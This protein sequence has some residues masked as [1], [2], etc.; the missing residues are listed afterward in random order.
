[1]NVLNFRDNIGRKM[2]QTLKSLNGVVNVDAQYE[3]DIATF[4]VKFDWGVDS[5][6]AY[7]LT[8]S[9]AAIYQSLLPSNAPKIKSSY[10]D[11]GL[12]LYVAVKS[13][14]KSAEELSLLL[15]K[16]LEPKLKN[17]QGISSVYISPVLDKEISIKVD[18]HLLAAHHLSMVD[19]VEHISQARFDYSLGVLQAY[20]DQ[21]ELRVVYENNRDSVSK[22]KSLPILIDAGKILKLGDIAKIS[23][24][25]RAQ[26]RVFKLNGESVIAIA[27]W[28]LPNTD[29]YNIAHLFEQE[30]TREIGKDGSVSI[31]NSPIKY[32]DDSIEQMS[33]AVLFGM[34][35][36]G[37]SVGLAFRTMRLA[38][39]IVLTMPL[40]I[41]VSVCFLHLSGVGINIITISAVG[42]AIGMVVDPAVFVVDR[43][44]FALS[45]ESNTNSNLA[46]VVES[47]VKQS[48]GSVFSTTLSTVAVFLPLAFTQPV[49]KALLGDFVIVITCLLLTSLFVSLLVVP[50][51]IVLCY[52]NSSVRLKVTTS[53]SRWLAQIPKSLSLERLLQNKYVTFPF[54]VMVVIS[55]CWSV[56]LLSYD[57]KRE[58]VAQP[59]PNIIDVSL[60]FTSSELDF[61]AR[62][63]L[64]D[65]VYKIIESHSGDSVKFMF[66][67]IRKDVAYLSLH[68][69]DNN[70]AEELI[71]KLKTLVPPTDSYDVDISPWVSASLKVEDLPNVRIF[72]TGLPHEQ[73]VEMLKKTNDFLRSYEGV[74]KVKTYPST[75]TNDLL[76]VKIK[77]DVLAW[78]DGEGK[79][80]NY[81]EQLNN[82]VKYSVAPGYMYDINSNAYD[83]P[84]MLQL[85]EHRSKSVEQL[86]NVPI[87]IN[88]DIFKL[89]QLAD[90]TVTEKN[91]KYFSR[92]SADVYLLEV[93]LSRTIIH[94]EPYM[95]E[96]LNNVPGIDMNYVNVSSTDLEVMDNVS[97]LIYAL[98][99]A[100]I[101]VLLILLLDLVKIPYVVIALSTLPTGI[102]G[103][104][105][106]LYSFESTLSVTSLVG[107]I[108]LAGL[109][110]NNSIFIIHG[111]KQI[112]SIQPDM[113]AALKVVAAVRMRLNAVVV[114]SLSTLCAMLPLAL[115]FGNSG[116]ITQPLGLVMFGG[117]LTSALFSLTLTPVLLYW[118]ESYAHKNVVKMSMLDLDYKT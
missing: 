27:A 103:A 47:A 75:R 108:M 9:S 61:D 60:N 44:R 96:L 66:S 73:S 35:F 18:Q 63:G 97:S 14:G 8:A 72:F 80:L 24:Q 77:D 54:F 15:K 19:I 34:C 98:Y 10:Y 116:P 32:I 42:I 102:I 28:P 22:L 58:I 65:P 90:F 112:K 100:L 68:L 104:A 5:E 16:R 81:L 71:G 21:P 117:G 36:A 107:L 113:S 1:M 49:V 99:A 4:M 67:D 45:A 115:G 74:I 106:A 93:W 69:K 17:I 101:L 37:L 57:V 59:L 23:L 55:S 79:Y 30:V 111:L 31:I 2:E 52:R 29:I 51:L 109:S 7:Q 105:L 83:I 11:P 70:N 48:Y 26:D 64:F 94:S 12:E 39:I 88:G 3:P 89:S 95:L 38:S 46:E 43:I 6:Q 84:V 33:I 13:K 41:M 62:M 91:T 76:N 20:E 86:E 78:L 114:T 56:Y 87:E 82:I 92:N 110:V 53:E 50:T 118:Y 25:V 40:S 85:G